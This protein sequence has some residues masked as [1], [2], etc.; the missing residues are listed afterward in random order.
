MREKYFL[1]S[2]TYHYE[3]ERIFYGIALAYERF[4]VYEV[5]DQFFALSESKELVEDLVYELNKNRTTPF[6]FRNIVEKLF[7]T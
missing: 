7:G 6:Y 1:T 5:I 2:T 4:G 3:K